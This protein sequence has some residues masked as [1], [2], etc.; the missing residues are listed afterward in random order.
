[1]Y[2]EGEKEWDKERECQIGSHLLETVQNYYRQQGNALEW[3]I[4]G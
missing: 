4:Q 1:M 2:F 3:N